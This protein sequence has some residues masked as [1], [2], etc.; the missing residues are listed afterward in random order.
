MKRARLAFA[1]ISLALLAAGGAYELLRN[2]AGVAGNSTS[3]GAP[4]ARPLPVTAATVETKDFPIYESVSA[5]CKPIT[6]SP[7]S[8]GSTAN[9]E[10]R[11]PR[12]PGRANR[13]PARADRSTTLRS[14][15]PPGRSRQGTRRGAAGEREADL[16]RFSSLAVKEFATQQSVDTQKALVGQ[17]GGDPT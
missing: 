5:P 4:P 7:S 9:T 10:D 17:T 14:P 2:T 1:A 15:S 13:R 3:G 12:R 6:P 11:L 16:E 8:G